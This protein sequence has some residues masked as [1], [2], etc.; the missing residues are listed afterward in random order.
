MP[1]VADL[2]RRFAALLE[3]RHTFDVRRLKAAEN[4][5]A[6]HEAEAAYDHV[7]A[8]AGAI[9]D[10]MLSRPVTTLADATAL[11]VQGFQIAELHDEP[12]LQR[13]F[14]RIAIVAG[15][16]AKISLE[17]FG[18]SDT[19]KLIRRHAGAEVAL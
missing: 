5:E 11:A 10:L 15:Q 14:A 12:K 1:S 3:Q 7:F 6:K 17:E 2:G 9:A 13:A 19:I 4:S 8:E 16:A 18:S